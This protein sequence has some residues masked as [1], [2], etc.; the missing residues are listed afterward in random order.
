MTNQK[1]TESR[2]TIPRSIKI[3]EELEQSF[4]EAAK[5]NDL[6]HA[7]VTPAGHEMVGGA[8]AWQEAALKVRE[9]LGRRRAELEHD[10]R[11]LE[12]L[13]EIHAKLPELSM[14]IADEPEGHAGAEWIPAV[15]SIIRRQRAKIAEVESERARAFNALGA[16]QYNLEE[17]SRERDRFRNE[18]ATLDRAWREAEKALAE[19]TAA[20]DGLA[21]Q[22]AEAGRKNL[23]SGKAEIAA[24]IERDA[25]LEQASAH[26]LDVDHATEN[27]RAWRDKADAYRTE[28]E[29]L[30]K[31]IGAS[32]RREPLLEIGREL[33]RREKE[34]NIGGASMKLFSAEDMSA[35]TIADRAKLKCAAI[36]VLEVA[37]GSGLAAARELAMGEDVTDRFGADETGRLKAIVA[38]F[39]N[40]AKQIEEQSK[41]GGDVRLEA[42]GTGCRE[43]IWE[44]AEQIV[45]EELSAGPHAESKRRAP[46]VSPLSA[47]QREG[48]DQALGEM[49]ATPREIRIRRV[50]PVM[51]SVA[52]QRAIARARADLGEI[53]RSKVWDAAVLRG[54][55]TRLLD[56]F[57]I[58]KIGDS[59][60]RTPSGSGVAVVNVED[61]EALQKAY[62]R[63][64]DRMAKRE[65]AETFSAGREDFHGILVE[66]LDS[67]RTLPFASE[68][69]EPEA[70]DVEKLGTD[71]IALRDR[72]NATEVHARSGVI[73]HLEDA[74]MLLKFAPE[75]PP[76]PR[77]R[78]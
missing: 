21:K 47:D 40:R 3:L 27:A 68:K 58:E 14:L 70:D 71:L 20:R 30:L 24:R 51:L 78:P 32:L 54:V 77:K 50:E 7:P 55:L 34:R 45:R 23:A 36:L 31:H 10:G 60:A 66:L 46:A 74:W 56:A 69:R 62:R 11:V 76:L 61:V 6:G 42:Y 72:V 12:Q 64:E 28:N 73:R 9:M 39:R 1:T 5:D 2:R 19:M 53:D 15:M 4:L 8:A 13:D 49:R 59:A 29:R 44:Q 16:S 41:A 48:L 18:N 25:A 38:R 67:L 63:A 75:I 26:R 35:I 57:A 33:R 65:L 22:F 52:A 37:H 17:V 43:A